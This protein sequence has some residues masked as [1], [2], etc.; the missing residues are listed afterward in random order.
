MNKSKF[1]LTFLMIFIIALLG[2]CTPADTSPPSAENSVAESAPTQ[3]AAPTAEPTI[4]VVSEAPGACNNAFYPIRGD[5]TWTYQFVH[6]NQE[7]NQGSFSLSYENLADDS[8]ETVMILRDPETDE[9][10]E[11]R[12]TWFCSGEG[13][14]A[15]EFNT[16]SFVT[17]GDVSVETLDYE[18]FSLLPEEQWEIN[19][20]WP[21]DYQVNASFNVD[22]IAV[23]TSMA[24]SLVNTVTAVEEITVSSG[25]YPEAYRVD[26][27]GVMN[28]DMEGIDASL[29]TLPLEYS[30]WYVQNVGMVKQE[31]TG[32]SADGSYTELVSID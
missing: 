28:M 6:P 20:T 10:F 2:A 17:I 16:F 15:S 4:G 24:I 3:T 1:L 29:S 23:S 19:A 5:A 27:V 30:T 11:A 13:L 18:G 22:E 7:E 31:T 25:T 21:S 12:G 32:E 8:F 14:V 26:T 9:I